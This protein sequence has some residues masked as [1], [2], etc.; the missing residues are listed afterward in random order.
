M[1]WPDQKIFQ[2]Y[3]NLNKKFRVNKM[4]GSSRSP[5]R[6][7]FSKLHVDQQILNLQQNTRTFDTWVRK[8]L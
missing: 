1:D 6:G 4:G 7:F 5:F 3:F 8:E 2:A